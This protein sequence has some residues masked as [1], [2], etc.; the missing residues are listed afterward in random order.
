MQRHAVLY[1]N[2][3]AFENYTEGSEYIHWA[4]GKFYDDFLARQVK[5]FEAVLGCK[6]LKMRKK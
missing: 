6:C 4:S 2:G 1:I 3:T 5:R